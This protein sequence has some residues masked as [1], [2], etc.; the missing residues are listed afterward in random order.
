MINT[1]NEALNECKSRKQVKCVDEHIEANNLS[2]FI[3][4]ISSK[5]NDTHTN[6]IFDVSYYRDETDE[7]YDERLKEYA[8]KI[9]YYKAKFRRDIGVMFSSIN[10]IDKIKS[11]ELDLIANCNNLQHDLYLSLKQ[12]YEGK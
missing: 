1:Y 7:E 3:N 11:S 9:N 2:D 10:D 6:F 5:Y 4:I 12:K 8:N